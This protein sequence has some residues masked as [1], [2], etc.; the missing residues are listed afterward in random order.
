MYSFAVL[1]PRPH[2]QHANTATLAGPVLGVEVTVPALAQACSL[3]NIDPQ[4]LGADAA[5]AAIEAALAWP[6]PPAGAT[7]A[8]VRADADALGAMAVLLLR[9]NGSPLL[10][11]AIERI[12]IIAEADKEAAGPW[13]GPRPAPTPEDLLGP[14]TPVMHLAADHTRPLKER[15][16]LIAEWIGHGKDAAAEA[17][18]AGYQERALAEAREALESLTVQAGPVAVVTG[19]HRLAMGLGYR[20]APV[21][22]ACNPAFRF[23]GGEPHRKHT[24]ARW[25]SVTIVEL[26]WAAMVEELNAADPA[27]TDTARWGGSTS[28]VGSPMGIASGLSAEQVAAI[29]REHVRSGLLD[30][31]RELVRYMDHYDVLQQRG[32]SYD[33][34][35]AATVR[36]QHQWARAALAELDGEHS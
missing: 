10:A 33:A 21:V 29:V 18:L 22:V 9:A 24:V 16:E 31:C 6:L 36:A 4:H 14:A 19:S 11:G 17:I 35:D 23:A 32:E 20:Y 3:G 5:T 25:N 13:P 15:V 2:A 26:E 12:Q 27:A 34:A 8:T 1:D 28:I 7:L 30:M